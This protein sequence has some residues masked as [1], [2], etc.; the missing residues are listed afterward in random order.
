MKKERFINLKNELN[1]EIESN[2]K[3]LNM[4]ANLKFVSVL[5]LIIFIIY[6]IRQTNKT[7]YIILS[8]ICFIIAAVLHF[9]QI[10]YQA[11]DNKLNYKLIIINDYLERFK[12]NPSFKDSGEDFKTDSYKS[13]DK[14]FESD[15]DIYGKKSIYSFISFSKTPI[16]RELT[17]SSLNANLKS[18]EEILQSQKA[19]SYFNRNIEDTLNILACSYE[20]GNKNETVKVKDI[21]TSLEGLNNVY[22]VSITQVLISVLLIIS[23]I[24]VIVLCSLKIMPVISLG[25]LLAISYFIQSFELSNFNSLSNDLSSAHHTLYGYQY[26]V[27]VISSTNF[28]NELLNNEKKKVSFLSKKS[29]IEF[30]ILSGLA[31]S[32]KNLLFQILF[33][34]TIM[35][36]LY[37]AIFYKNWQ[38]KY[39]DHF[40]EALVSIGNIEKYISLATISLTKEESVTPSVSSTFEF[41]NIR[42]PLINEINCIPNSFTFVGRNIITGSNMS[43]KTTFMRSIGTNYVLFLAGSD[44]CATRFNAPILKLFTSMKVVDDVNNN[45]STF[46][47]EI[48]R[49][50]GIVEYTKENLPMLVLVD[51]IFKGTNT[52]DRIIGAK[53]AIDKLNK[54]NIYSIVTTHDPE[55]CKIDDVSNF[56]FEEH[57]ED[58]QIKFDYKIHDG[59][60][61]TSNAIYLL[62]LAGIIDEE[63]AKN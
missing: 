63:K 57:Y 32:R 21:K 3:S 26:L 1:Q 51:E 23:Y 8:I 28:D 43:G 4:Y 5:L 17:A 41:D 53:S 9:F 25:A 60:S 37:V 47:G 14:F 48:L 34:S 22:K 7:P 44:V 55:L 59:I 24:T 13:N 62:K 27:E 50:K 30:N 19:S 38:K 58:D 11:I 36:T 54:N 46:Y 56:H 45:I 42:H 35:T 33:D 39:K 31:E 29:I 40:E 20:F 49:V 52:H 12:D 15:L 10:H 61:Q 2:K 16:G 6:L 18:E